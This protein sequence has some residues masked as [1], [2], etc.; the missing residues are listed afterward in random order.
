MSK[1]DLL[2]PIAA[3]LESQGLTLADLAEYT[4][5]AVEAPPRKQTIKQFAPTA[6]RGLSKNSQRSYQTHFN[7]LINGIARQ[8]E[9]GCPICLKEYAR[10][11]TCTCT[12]TRNSCKSART[13]PAHGKVIV[14]TRNIASIDLELMVELVQIMAV[15]RAKSENIVRARRGLSIKP[16]HGQG[17][18]EMCV[19]ALRRLKTRMI[20]KSL[21]EPDAEKGPKK[22]TRG[23]PTRGALTDTELTEVFS[24]VA[25]GGDDPV[26]DF[27]LTWSE[28]ELAARRGGVLSLAVGELDGE[29]QMIGLLEKGDKYERQPCSLDLIEFLLEFA[30]S[31]GGDVCVP[32]SAFYDPNAPVFYF[33]DS[34]IEQPHAVTS[35]RFDTLHR[36]IQLALPWA[37]SMSYSGH[38]LRH[39]STVIDSQS[40]VS[41][42]SAASVTELKTALAT[43]VRHPR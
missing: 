3:M 32:G 18:R 10:A 20:E 41:N 25:S 38:A 2:G 29:A 14:T 24:T 27:A 11:G 33:K 21:I 15:K 42:V 13:F 4:R 43:L 35:R 8:C 39:T 16:T 30:A 6:L 1:S 40:L 36:R 5:N 19:T 34:T 7:H 9:C 22:G 26:L 12:C 37:N 23:Q 31:R 28:F 17:A